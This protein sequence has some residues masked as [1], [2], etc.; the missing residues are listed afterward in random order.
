MR[1][2]KPF[3]PWI[4]NIIWSIY[5]LTAVWMSW[6]F[7]YERGY[8][9]GFLLAFS[10]SAAFTV[11][12]WKIFLRRRHGQRIEKRAL[13]ELAYAIGRRQNAAMQASVPL[14]SGGD[15]DAV[16][17]MGGTRFNIELKSVE[18]ARKVTATHALQAARAAKELH[19]IPVIWLPRA[20]SLFSS[21]KKGVRIVCGD[22]KTLLRTLDAL[23]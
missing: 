15:A 16:I 22:T 12:H 10:L 23:L 9:T 4:S 11:W 6:H 8:F 20:I 13:K 14:H 2:T 21:E 19:S 7:L 5:G 1:H 18:D 17:E 3:R